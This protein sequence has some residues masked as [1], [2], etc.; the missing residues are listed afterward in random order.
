MGSDSPLEVPYHFGAESCREE[1]VRLLGAVTEILR[2]DLQ[3]D[4][5]PESGDTSKP[6]L[7]PLPNLNTEQPDQKPQSNR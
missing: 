1:W 7:L 3:P 4:I 6:A 2:S 5:L